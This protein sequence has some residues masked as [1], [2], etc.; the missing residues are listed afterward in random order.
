MG[1]RAADIVREGLEQLILTGELADGAHLDEV[2]LATRFDVSRTPLREALQAL[3]A[4]GLVE[5]IPNRGAFV[6]NPGIQEMVEMFEVMAEL[7]GMCGRLAA[8]RVSETALAEIDGA[9]ARCEDAL[10]QGDSDEYYRRNERFHQLLY[11]ASGNG[12]LAKEALRLQKRLQPYRRMQLRVR[13]RMPQSMAEHRE[14]LDAIRAGDATRAERA[15]RAHVAVQ[16]EK[17]N[18]L[19]ASLGPVA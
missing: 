5:L 6:R 11:A 13:G 19:L 17:F 8:R 15:L 10:A 18:D 9:A 3:S 14:I 16:G 7:E 4:S 1:R 12:F 2:R